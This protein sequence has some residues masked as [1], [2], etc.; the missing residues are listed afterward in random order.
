MA[1]AERKL[2]RCGHNASSHKKITRLGVPRRATC[3]YWN[4]DCDL[5][6]TE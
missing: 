1:R 5:F 6:V 2:C 3:E 4:C